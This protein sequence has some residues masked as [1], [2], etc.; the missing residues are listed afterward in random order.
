[1]NITWPGFACSLL[2]KKELP[3]SSKH[4]ASRGCG[5]R[6]SMCHGS[7]FARP[8]FASQV[9][10]PA[11]VSSR[12]R[13]SSSSGCVFACLLVFRSSPD[14][15]SGSVFACPCVFAT[16]RVF[17]R[18]VFG[19]CLCPP[20]SVFA[21]PRVFA[22]RRVF[23]RPVFGKCLCPP[24]SVFAR[25]VSS[26]RR[27]SS[28]DL[29]SGSVFARPR[30]LATRRVFARPGIETCHRPATCLRNDA[31]PRPTCLR[32]VSSHAHVSS[33]RRVSSPDL[34]SATVFSREHGFTTG[35]A[36]A[37]AVH[38][39]SVFGRPRIF[40]PRSVFAGNLSSLRLAY[41]C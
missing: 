9:S 22:K 20:G 25:P 36:L 16:R 1:M 12:R 30:V 4:T 23:A 35:S 7:V 18:P 21:R 40:A 13:V 24:G 41:V 29:S 11:H 38:S 26:R 5:C 32:D 28:P 19:K 8:V 15:A 3:C 2:Q 10:S 39:P 37:R 6:R 34:S 14:L 31:C 17:A 33:P 27:V